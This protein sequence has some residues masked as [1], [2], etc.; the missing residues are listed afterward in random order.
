[1]SRSTLALLVTGSLCVA[2]VCF[3][4]WRNISYSKDEIQQRL[5]ILMDKKLDKKIRSIECYMDFDIQVNHVSFDCHY[6]L[7]PHE[8]DFAVEIDTDD[9][10][11]PFWASRDTSIAGLFFSRIGKHRDLEIS[12]PITRK[13]IDKFT[14][15]DYFRLK[16]IVELIASKANT[17][18]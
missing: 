9:M 7:V 4:I 8:S 12:G 1:M 5:F 2:F 16:E 13:P 18:Q 14:N 6:I 11:G 17:H 10:R 3:D 15:S